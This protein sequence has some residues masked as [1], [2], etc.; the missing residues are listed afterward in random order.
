L[1]IENLTLT[2]KTIIIRSM[3]ESGEL[4]VCDLETKRTLTREGLLVQ[5]NE[6]D[7]AINMLLP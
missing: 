3:I 5:M 2:E 7:I 6:K 1:N 4:C